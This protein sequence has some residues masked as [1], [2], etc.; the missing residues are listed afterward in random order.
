[1]TLEEFNKWKEDFLIEHGFGV[2]M[3]TMITFFMP[4]FLWFAN[5]F[6]KGKFDKYIGLK[7]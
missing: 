7:K 6:G 5:A 4:L 2:V 3:W 1:M